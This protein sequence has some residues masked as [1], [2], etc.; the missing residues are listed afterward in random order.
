MN[1][2]DHSRENIGSRQRSVRCKEKDSA[3]VYNINNSKCGD[4]VEQRL[5]NHANKAP[6][7]SV[8]PSP[9][10]PLALSWTSG[11]R[12]TVAQ[13]VCVLTEAADS[14]QKSCK[15]PIQHPSTQTLLGFP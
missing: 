2:E 3:T 5:F 12:M 7:D 15:F 8:N 10:R 4:E 1:Q 9:R 13:R 14:I 6:A 11:I